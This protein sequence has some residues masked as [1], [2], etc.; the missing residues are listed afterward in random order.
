M[1][2]SCGAAAANPAVRGLKPRLVSEN[3]AFGGLVPSLTLPLFP[4]VAN[5]SSLMDDSYCSGM[6]WGWARRSDWANLPTELLEE[7]ATRLLT[8][9]VSEYLRLRSACKPWR[10]CTDDPSLSGGGLDP[11][12]RPH[13]WIAVS[14]CASPSRRRLINICT[15]ARAEVDRPELSTHHCFGIVDGLLVLCDKATSAVRLLNPLT[16]ALVHGSRVGMVDPLP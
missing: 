5:S 10:K 15:G 1:R 9:D 3:G 8:V 16:G 12:F 6:G 4:L 2:I 13:H 7:I 11:R 14:H